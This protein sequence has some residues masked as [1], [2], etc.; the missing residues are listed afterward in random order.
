MPSFFGGKALV[1]SWGDFIA[2]MMASSAPIDKLRER[3]LDVSGYVEENVGQLDNLISELH[4]SMRR[5]EHISPEE[6]TQVSGELMIVAHYL[7]CRFTPIREALLPLSLDDIFSE[8]VN[9]QACYQAII[10]M[11]FE[12]DFPQEVASD[13]PDK[14]RVICKDF[15][16]LSKKTKLFERMIRLLPQESLDS[17]TEAGA[18][19]NSNLRHAMKELITSLLN[20]ARCKLRLA[21]KPDDEGYLKTAD[22]IWKLAQ[23][24]K[25]YFEGKE[26]ERAT[27]I[28]WYQQSADYYA[29]HSYFHEKR[30]R[31]SSVWRMDVIGKVAP[32]SMIDSVIERLT[33]DLNNIERWNKYEVRVE[34][35]G[36]LLQQQKEQE[37]DEPVMTEAVGHAYAAIYQKM[38]ARIQKWSQDAWKIRQHYEGVLRGHKNYLTLL[39]GLDGKLRDLTKAVYRKKAELC[40][41]IEY[42]FNDEFF[43]R[44]NDCLRALDAEKVGKLRWSNWVHHTAYAAKQTEGYLAYQMNTWND[45]HKREDI[46]C[47][48]VYRL[49]DTWT[50]SDFVVEQLH[51]I[52]KEVKPSAS[53]ALHPD[54]SQSPAEGVVREA[55]F[56]QLQ[57]WLSHAAAMRETWASGQWIAAAPSDSLA[58]EADAHSAAISLSAQ[59]GASQEVAQVIEPEEPLD[60]TVLQL[61]YVYLLQLEGRF[62]RQEDAR[63]RTSD[64]IPAWRR[65]NPGSAEDREFFEQS[66][67]YEMRVRQV[68]EERRRVLA[69]LEAQRLAANRR[70]EEECRQKEEVRRQSSES[71][72][73]V[74]SD[75]LSMKLSV[76]CFQ[77][78]APREREVF[79][80][81]QYQAILVLLKKAYKHIPE[82]QLKAEILV[83]LSSTEYAHLRDIIPAAAILTSVAQN[84][85]ALYSPREAGA[86]HHDRLDAPLLGQR[87][88]L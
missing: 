62:S 44:A 38:E 81:Q 79:Y 80:E 32:T 28:D 34:L 11:L 25:L 12:K 24:F 88:A 49:S 36:A 1:F 17:T 53:L 67:Q 29:A 83:Q 19:V 50:M 23:Y 46:G 76:S 18:H 27:L 45:G 35:M 13:N 16:E 4:D 86:S 6:K 2:E 20:W 40:A 68:V 42:L 52:W 74:T 30:L 7:R 8:G 77:G 10:K 55:C 14:K 65:L 43:S 56:K 15:A 54:K 78:V 9:A 3:W 66:K 61:H 60:L 39:T 64:E 48:D 84:R 5:N 41:D 37:T 47:F 58:I 75:Y 31:D 63:K 70:A 72:R 73:V 71:R 57:V 21:I 85:N 59:T 51:H 87:K 82:E 33:E 26:D 22:R 69:E